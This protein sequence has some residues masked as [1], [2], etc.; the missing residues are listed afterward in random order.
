MNCKKLLVTSMILTSCILCAPQSFSAAPMKVQISKNYVDISRMI[1]YTNYAEADAKLKEIL[2]KNPNDLEAKALQLMSFAKQWKLAP[3]QSELDKLLAKYPNN[4]QLHYAQGLVYLMRE[5]S[6][7]VEYIKNIT[8]LSNAAIQEFVK[9]VDLDS[10]YYQAY[11]AM[12]VA[13]LKLGNKKDAQD[14]FKVALKINPQ[15][16]PA[17][18]NLGNITMLDNDLDQSE[19]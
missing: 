16:A 1:E 13:T 6:S 15:F 4:P 18:D 11:N 17:Y 7:D 8:N 3:A 10:T 9:A 2:Q 5:T 19:K 12:G 14:L